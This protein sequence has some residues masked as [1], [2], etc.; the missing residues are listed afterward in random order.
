MSTLRYTHCTVNSA[1]GFEQSG[2]TLDE[3]D[4][5]INII[6]GP[7]AAGKTT[8]AR[9]MQLLLWPH[10]GRPHRNRKS[11]YEERVHVEARLRA[12]DT[13][14]FAEYDR[15]RASYQASHQPSSETSLQAG[16]RG[17]AESGRPDAF[18]APDAQPRY[19]LALHELIQADSDNR[20]FADLIRRESVGGFDLDAAAAATVE[21]S[22]L[23]GKRIAEYKRFQE[24]KRRLGEARAHVDRLRSMEREL[25]E[26]RRTEEE[27]RRAARRQELYARLQ[28]YKEHSR[29]ITDLEEEL[30][31]YPSALEHFA[32]ADAEQARDLEVRIAQ[33]RSEIEAEE[34]K[35]Q[36][37]ESQLQA[38]KFE[39]SNDFA[40]RLAVW[41]EKI[42][43]L[44]KR[45]QEYEQQ[46]VRLAEAESRVSNC[47]T[48]LGKALEAAEWEGVKEPELPRARELSRQAESLR[49]ASKAVNEQL[50]RVPEEEPRYEKETLRRG[51]RSFA[52]LLLGYRRGLPSV[53]AGVG[54]VVLLLAVAAA[55][56]NAP[57]AIA[58]AAAGAL[59]FLVALVQM[60]ARPA[61]TTLIARYEKQG[62][63]ELTP[64]TWDEEAAKAKLEQLALQL[65]S[66][67]YLREMQRRR[68]ELEK[69]REEQAAR[70]EDHRQAWQELRGQLGALPDFLDE[71]YGLSWFLE[72]A[73]RLRK[74]I[75]DR[76]AAAA[77][78]DGIGREIRATLGELQEQWAP[79]YSEELT[80][81]E[82]AT[83]GLSR[84]AELYSEHR[85]LSG[86]LEHS[87][88][89]RADKA[90][91]LEREQD[92]REKLY[93]RFGLKEEEAPL[94]VLEQWEAL[95][96]RYD[97]LRQELRDA[98]RDRD[99]ALRGLRDN[100]AF[101]E[102]LLD[103]GLDAIKAERERYAAQ[104]DKLDETRRRITEIET[105]LNNEKRT[106]DLEEALAE[107]DAAASQL[108][109]RRDRNFKSL[110][111][112]ALIRNLKERVRRRERPE[113]FHEANRLFERL[114]VGQFRL[115]LDEAEAGTFRA[116]DTARGKSLTLDQLSSGTRIQLLLAVRVAFLSRSEQELRLPLFV[117][118]VLANSDDERARL[119]IETLIRIAEEGRQIFYFTAQGDEVARWRQVL[120][121]EGWNAKYRITSLQ[122]GAAESRLAR[123][124]EEHRSFTAP[125][126]LPKPDGMT[127][128]EY[129]D[130]LSVPRYHPLV[131]PVESL[132]IWYVIEES[133]VIHALASRS[134]HRLGPLRVFLEG[135]GHISEL[136][137][138]FSGVLGEMVDLLTEAVRLY[139]I[140]RNVPVDF[141]VI[142]ESGAVTDRFIDVVR[143]IHEEV[144]GEPRRLLERMA[145]IPK[146]QNAKL[147]QLEEYLQER[148]YLSSREPYSP[149]HLRAHMQARI[150]R[151]RHLRR[152]CAENALERVL[153]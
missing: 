71:E 34:N 153:G 26:L 15:G 63:K 77:G 107:R 54:A 60:L 104:A 51:L 75:D 101:D 11:D 89:R 152:E 48:D 124:E 125:S 72:Q 84:L 2:F 62:L 7:N 106:H 4:A 81:V 17:T 53:V 30:A 47:H 32:E 5:R 139:R 102:G 58:L 40:D 76:D 99:A 23:K 105:N 66:D 29:R 52:D 21:E 146:F 92:K 64:E 131:E 108:A 115:E 129:G 149:E 73:A 87:R 20:S 37:L 88:D 10:L 119:I 31:G 59:C 16:N 3:L 142:Q 55:F 12:D 132:H 147:E 56:F 44:K 6:Y 13:S 141:S 25:E 36:D 85:R 65:G 22:D 74:A 90:Q 24:A 27:Q 148:E 96:P 118:E 123:P 116:V 57:V 128:A 18:L 150:T 137:E 43:T 144:G 136:P 133:E 113:V 8:T 134:I 33:Y 109:E 86:D 46:K 39:P 91:Q 19:N 80:D 14:W 103:K 114:T 94:Q 95:A 111:A 126:P 140:G 110:V 138:D 151:L 117:D 97:E 69:D 70:E 67:E 98:T 38:L 121:E 145:D 93:E 61:R 41:R 1:P 42:E 35:L 130:V 143:E 83:A 112:D 78:R 68:A 45:R 79:W 127:H 9:A 135:G 49:A 28:S 120:D 100:D 122:P 50:K 82:T